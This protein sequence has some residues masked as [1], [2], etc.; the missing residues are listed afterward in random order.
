MTDKEQ[1]VLVDEFIDKMNLECCIIIGKVNGK[2]VV[3]MLCTQSIAMST[4]SLLS[5]APQN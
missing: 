3:K 2:D 4:G 5:Y 1:N